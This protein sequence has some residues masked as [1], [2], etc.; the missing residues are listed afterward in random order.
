MHTKIK[1][2]GS[3]SHYTPINFEPYYVFTTDKKYLVKCIDY[4]NLI[5]T[6]SPQDLINIE[7]DIDAESI[8]G[9]NLVNGEFGGCHE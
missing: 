3:F 7:A 9:T 4:P 1:F 5:S 2:T 8:N 6:L